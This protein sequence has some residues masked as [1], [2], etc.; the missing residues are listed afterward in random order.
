M[1]VTCYSRFAGVCIK[2]D[3][4]KQVK[5]DFDWVLNPTIQSI[6]ISACNRV[7]PVDAECCLAGTEPSESCAFPVCSPDWDPAQL[8]PPPH[9]ENPCILVSQFWV[10]GCQRR[11]W[12]ERR[13]GE[14]AG[15]VLRRAGALGWAGH[16]H[17]PDSLGPGSCSEAC[18]PR[19]P[20]PCPAPSTEATLGAGRGTS[21][22]PS[23]M[24]AL[25]SREGI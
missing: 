18:R 1:R 25:V 17:S 15:Q 19:G 3:R 9:H 10:S 20:A 13:A 4:H 7:R 23:G 5:S 2:G 22:L 11:A 16:G 6:V 8:F 12:L 14:P 24:A 21:F